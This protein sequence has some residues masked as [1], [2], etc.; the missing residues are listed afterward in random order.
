MIDRQSVAVRDLTLSSGSFDAATTGAAWLT[1]DCE[2][3]RSLSV[4][5]DF[6]RL[7]DLDR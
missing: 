3:L 7:R 5:E 6:S 4:V 2:A 1:A